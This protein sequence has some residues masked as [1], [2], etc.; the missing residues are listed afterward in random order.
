MPFVEARYGTTNAAFSA[1]LGYCAVG[2]NTVET[3]FGRTARSWVYLVGVSIP[4]DTTNDTKL[5]FYVG[6]QLGMTTGMSLSPSLGNRT[7]FGLA[8]SARF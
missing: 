4:L 3:E 1:W 5:S 6:N 7:G 2:D 8:L